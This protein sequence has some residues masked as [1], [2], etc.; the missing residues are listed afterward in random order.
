[1]AIP[2]DLPEKQGK[3]PIDSA[4]LSGDDCP[5]GARCD[6]GSSSG[7]GSKSGMGATFK[8][9]AIKNNT[10]RLNIIKKNPDD[11]GF[12]GDDDGELVLFFMKAKGI[13]IESL[14]I[15]E[16]LHYLAENSRRKQQQT[17]AGG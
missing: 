11:P 15:D 3:N 4:S 10:D 16:L 12:D 14:G 17:S 5:P 13:E 6:D 1:M 7:G 9:K 8:T 2:T